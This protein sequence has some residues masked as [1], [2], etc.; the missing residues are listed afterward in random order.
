MDGARAGAT[1]RGVGLRENRVTAG[2][3]ERDD[4]DAGAPPTRP[5]RFLGQFSPVARW[6]LIVA[7]LLLFV[8]VALWSQRRPIASNFINGVLA[9]RGVAARYRVADIGFDTQ[10]LTDVVIGDP[11]RPD[12]VADWVEVATRVTLSGPVVTGLRAGQVRLRARYVGG[13]LTLGA[14]DRFATGGGRAVTLPSVD[15]SVADGR[16]RLET[17]Y[18]MAGVKLSG[19][20]RLNDGFRGHA[21]IVADRLAAEGCRIDQFAA[22]VSIAVTDTQ[23]QVRGPVRATSIDCAG[24]GARGVAAVVDATLNQR[25]DRWR[26]SARLS[27]DAVAGQGAAADGLSG[28]IAFDGSARRTT[29][30]VDLAA[31]AFRSAVAKGGAARIEGRYHAGTDGAS[32]EGDA[33]AQQA[34]LTPAWQRRIAGFS[35]IAAGTPLA[36]IAAAVVRAG[37]TA[38]RRFAFQSAVELDADQRGYRLALART[39]LNAASGARV[40][41]NGGTGVEYD[42]RDGTMLNG[43]LA[44]TGGGLPE[45]AIRV[46]QQSP[47]APVTGTAL[48]RPYRAG[49]ARLALDM[50][51][52]T[53][54]PGGAT[55]LTTRVA[56][57]GPIGDGRVDNAVL[58]IEAYWRG[59]NR[60]RVNDG[61]NPLSFDRLRIGS[62]ALDRSRL[63]LCPVAGSMLLVDRGRVSGGIA[64][65]EPRLGGTLGGAPITI[66][67]DSFRYA[68]GGGLAARDVAV[69][70]GAPDRVT[71][72]DVAAI[73]GRFVGGGLEGG[74]AGGAGQIARVPLL[75][76]AAAGR[77]RFADTRLHLDGAL[78]V[79]DADPEPRFNPVA[80]RDVALSLIDN[81]I[82]ATGTLFEPTKG[83]KIAD[84]RIAH[85]LNRQS[86]IA[87]LTVP[88]IAFNDG[89]Q[90]DRLTR[91]TYGVI[92]DVVGRVS[93]AGQIRWDRDGVT[94]D[95][96]FRTTNTDLAAAFGPVTGLSGEIRFTDLLA[97]ETAPGQVATVAVVN[98]GVPVREGTVRYRALAG[99]RI[100]IEGARW[101]FAGGALILEP[102]VL[103]FA[104]ARERRLTFRVEGVDAAQFLQQFDFKNLDATGTFDGVLPMIFDETGGRIDNGRLKVREAGGG[105]IAYV[106]EVSQKDVGFWG[107]MAFQALKSLRYRTLDIVMNGP[108]AGEMITE[109]RF[110]GVSQGAGAKDNF[111]IRRLQKLPFVFNVRIQAPFRQLID[112]AQSFYDPRR[113]I[114]RNLPALIKAQDD[115]VRAAKPTPPTTSA[116]QPVKAPESE[117]MP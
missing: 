2:G 14:L 4:A 35:D 39:D 33:A 47:G 38:A 74:F 52:F 72:V 19:S 3:G 106:G 100:A 22:T 80:A 93:G 65:A 17:P 20:G 94:S 28:H 75:M 29:G 112:S 53:A 59:G 56:L 110:A 51:D 16:V 46:T 67:A 70:L 82:A 49:D 36:P 8:L 114:E 61:C 71:R 105:T 101:P 23:P 30:T 12:L 108:L 98:P 81:R 26:G 21:A 104:N 64:T 109:V 111:L 99:Q 73:D 15:V 41:L 5:R 89:F 57:S 18:G 50:V 7:S 83:V 44:V 103:D 91:L 62:L 95:G 85:D 32:F 27:A 31:G 45:A 11:R 48:I 42:S 10:R 115:A 24:V 13:R 58:P 113:L 90:P 25:F 79:A 102:A 55:R 60:L 78:T 96:V 40:T 54:A 117:H 88:G 34:S 43:L 37:T 92:A 116:D 69:R 107:N 86:G 63:T 6:S 68:I 84:V 9:G 87:D 66:A 97:L 77:W 1:G 76:S